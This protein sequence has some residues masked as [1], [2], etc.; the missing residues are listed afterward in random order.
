MMKRFSDMTGISIVASVGT[1]VHKEFDV[2]P[3]MDIPF[4]LRMQI[5]ERI[6]ERMDEKYEEVG[7]TFVTDR[8]PVDF[9]AYTLADVRRDG[10][11]ELDLRRV[12]R[13]IDNCYKVMNKHFSVLIVVPPAILYTSEPGKPYANLPYQQHIHLLCC[14]VIADQ[15]N[16]VHT[17]LIDKD[18]VSL[19]GRLESM[20]EQ[21]DR[22]LAFL[23]QSK[24]QHRLH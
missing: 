22:I 10:H 3:A 6:L 14:G 23:E 9:L 16:K 2:D 17:I 18:N 8:T 15:R 1:E 11:A 5:Q 4:G 12:E 7:Y 21:Y 13:Y 19:D 20:C 24:A